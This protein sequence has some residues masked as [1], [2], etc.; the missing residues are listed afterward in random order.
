MAIS[1][2]EIVALDAEDPAAVDEAYRIGEDAAHVDAPDLP[3]TCRYSFGME[4]RRPRPGS[5]RHAF[6]A[7]RGGEAVGTA[8]LD[9]PIRDNLDKAHIEV[10]VPAAHRRQGIG[11]A[12]Y[13]HASALARSRGRTSALGFSRATPAPS[14]FAAAFGLRNGLTDARR[15]LLVADVDEAALDRLHAEGL[16]RSAG[17]RAV[18]WVGTP[19]EELL[20][21]LAA[22]DSSF[23]AETPMGELEYEPENVSAE[24]MREQHEVYASYGSRRYQTVMIHEASG[25]VVAWSAIRVPKTVGWHAWQLI[26]L[27]HPAHRG[28]RLG[29]VAKVTNL[30]HLRAH[31]PAVTMIDT[32]NAAENSYMIAINE[33]MG[34]RLVDL[35]TNWQGPIAD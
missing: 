34:F 9:L 14:G 26:T 18:Q 21:D 31:E 30:R 16:A 35:W 5:E 2:L 19:P 7:Y 22:L 23:L 13:R 29:I 10:Y 15:R 1:T 27:V 33:A 3:P 12:L 11:R 6:L 20:A 25:R 17:Y 8:S 4:L 28:R 24:H 32:F